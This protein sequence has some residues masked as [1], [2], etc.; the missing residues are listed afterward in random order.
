MASEMRVAFAILL[1]LFSFQSVLVMGEGGVECEKLPVDMCAFSVSSVGVRCVLEKKYSF[2]TSTH[3][4][5]IEYQ[6]QS[7]GIMAEK[8]MEWI[9]SEVCLQTCGLQRMIVGMSTDDLSEYS[10][11]T[12]KLCSENCQNS[13]PNIVNLYLNLAAGEGIYLPHLCEAHKTRSR[14]M[15]FESVA[16]GPTLNTFSLAAAAPAPY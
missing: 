10:D 5:S 12:S 2:V 8:M 14:R 9:E 6:C 1:A 4:S 3:E 16:P 13:C 15:M 7:S 11:F